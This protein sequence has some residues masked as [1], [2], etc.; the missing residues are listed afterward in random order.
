M[1]GGHFNYN[2]YLLREIAQKIQEDI[3]IALKQK[4]EKVHE[5]Y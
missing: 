3:A 2:Q 4:P 1:S 5:N